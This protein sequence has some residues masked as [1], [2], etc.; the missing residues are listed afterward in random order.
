MYRNFLVGSQGPVSWLLHDC[1][2]RNTI[3]FYSVPCVGISQGQSSVSMRLCDL[4]HCT[5]M[6]VE[7][8]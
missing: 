7:Y 2:K 6:Y 8:T 1:G 4:M 5:S 3:L